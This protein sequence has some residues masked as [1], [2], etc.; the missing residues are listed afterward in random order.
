VQTG[1]SMKHTSVYKAGIFWAIQ[2]ESPHRLCN[3]SYDSS[4]NLATWIYSHSHAIFTKYSTMS[5]LEFIWRH[6]SVAE[7]SLY[8]VSSR[9]TGEWRT[10]ADTE[11]KSLIL[12]DAVTKPTKADRRIRVSYIVNIQ[13]RSVLYYKHVYNIRQSYTF[14]SICWFRYHIWSA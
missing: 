3:R 4:P 5:E 1:C 11:G 13:F 6:C 10:E 7:T 8:S 2:S 9:F 12:S 14:I